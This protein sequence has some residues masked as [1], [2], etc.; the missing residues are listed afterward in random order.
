LKLLFN[1]ALY[2]FPDPFVEFAFSSNEIFF[3]IIMFNPD[4][5][6]REIRSV[7]KELKRLGKQVK[8][9]REQKKKAESRLLEYMKRNSI[10]SYSGLHKE[11]LEKKFLIKTYK[12]AN[13][14]RE[15]AFRL[16]METG[17][18]DPENFWEKLRSTQKPNVEVPTI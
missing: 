10:A 6:V 18:P 8:D 17:I 2:K 11:L 12:K 3:L 1:H 4:S 15:E 16:F 7:E 14:K 5:C 13:E 9:L